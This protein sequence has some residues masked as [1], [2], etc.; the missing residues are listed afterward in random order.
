MSGTQILPGAV[1]AQIPTAWTIFETGDFDGDG[2]SDILWRDI[3]GNIAMWFMNGTQITS[4]P[5]I[6]Q[7]PTTWTIQGRNAD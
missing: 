5:I 6:G 2:K 1:I 4:G 7:I 3:S